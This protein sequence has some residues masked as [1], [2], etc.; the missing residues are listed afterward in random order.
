[1]EQD[2]LIRAILTVLIVGIVIPMTLWYFGVRFR[3]PQF[4]T[5]GVVIAVV[6]FAGA[7]IELGNRWF[8]L[9]EEATF[10]TGMPGPA[11]RAAESS[12]TQETPYYVKHADKRHFMELLPVAKLGEQ[13]IGS[14]T[15]RYEVRSP[16]D[17]M[18]AQ[19]QETLQPAKGDKWAAIHTEFPVHDIG[20]HKLVVEVPKPAGEVK[21]TISEVRR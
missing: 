8:G 4:K 9:S 11:R 15:L 2:E 14:L 6:Y 13:A 10:R 5:F 12:V 16:E 3:R 7:G 20:V 17:E 19:G 18:L 21:V 1:M